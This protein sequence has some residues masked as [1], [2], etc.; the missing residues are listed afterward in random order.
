MDFRE[1]DRY[2][3]PEPTG[4]VPVSTP[5]ERRGRG[6]G[7]LKLLLALILIAGAGGGAYYWRDKEAKDDAGL[8]SSQINQLQ[9]Q[10]SKL[11]S[12]LKTT[13]DKAAA[14]AASQSGPTD[15]TLKKV[16][17]AVKS[18]KYADM[19][20]LIAS[21]VN[22]VIAA[23]EG[24]GQRTPAQ[25][26]ADLKYLDSGTDPWN[27]ALASA[28]INGYQDGDYAQYFPVG[29]LVGK[30]ANDYVVSFVFNNSGKVIGIFIAA[31]ADL[32]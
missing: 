12:D 32:L 13:E 18:G 11:Q 3:P 9:Q 2:Q 8:Q 1:P 28:V 22:V 24:L 19:Q 15:D 25:A 21:K 16:Q 31:D 4:P 20:S 29:G 6:K 7:L 27:F 26:V 17:D 10:V 5:P 23:S 14:E 30:S